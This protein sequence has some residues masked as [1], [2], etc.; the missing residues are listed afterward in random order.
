MVPFPV[1]SPG[2]VADLPHGWPSPTSDEIAQFKK[3]KRMIIAGAIVFGLAYYGALTVG[4]VGVS[5]NTVGSNEYIP[6]LIPLVGPF[7]SAPFRAEP[8]ASQAPDYAGMTL[9]LGLGVTQL[10]GATVFVLGLREPTGAAPRCRDGSAARENTPCTK[11]DVSVAPIVSP[12]LS[13]VG[14]VGSF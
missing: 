10:V 11:S 12:S 2:A 8:N 9:M 3:K 6:T 14:V 1:T 7:I 13:G 5:V 4:S